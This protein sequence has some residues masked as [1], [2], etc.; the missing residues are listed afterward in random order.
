MIKILAAAV[1]MT[2]LAGCGGHVGRTSV[3]IGF[4][5]APIYVAPRRPYYRPFHR[6]G[7]RYYYRGRYRYG[8]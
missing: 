6:P 8:R 4:A 1:L 2:V 5:P 7:G 3:G